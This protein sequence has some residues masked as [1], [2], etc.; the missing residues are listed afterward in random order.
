MNR[1][2]P[3]TRIIGALVAA[4]ALI[5]VGAYILFP[6]AAQGKLPGQKQPT[7]IPVTPFANVTNAPSAGSTVAPATASAAVAS[8]PAAI[9]STSAAPA[10][11]STYAVAGDQSQAKVTV[12]EKLA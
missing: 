9:A 1:K 4:V 11:G 6:L 8:A 2:S 12:N 5:I 7:P 10:G 3:I